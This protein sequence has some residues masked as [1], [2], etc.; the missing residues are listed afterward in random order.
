MGKYLDKITF[1]FTL[2]LTTGTCSPLMQKCPCKID[3]KTNTVDCSR[4]NPRLTAIPNCIPSSVQ[5]LNLSHNKFY[6]IHRRQFKEF[7]KLV[8]LDLRGC[9]VEYLSDEAFTGLP[10]L[11]TLLLTDNWIEVLNTTHFV[12]LSKLRVLDLSFNHIKNI[13]ELTFTGLA[14]LKQLSMA[15]NRLTHL[16]SHIFDGL[17]TLK[18]L[19][20][21]TNRLKYASSFPLDVF[22]PLTSLEEINI[23]KTCFASNCT[24]IDA[25]LTVL[26]SLKILHMDG[27]PNQ[28]LGPGFNSL[29]NLEEIYFAE[30]NL[31]ETTEMTFYN[32]KNSRLRTLWLT[33]CYINVIRPFSFSS[34][35]NLDSLII[36]NN[37][38][39]CDEGLLNIT[40][41]LNSTRIRHIDVSWT[42]RTSWSLSPPTIDKLQSTNLEILEFASSNIVFINP[43]VFIYLPQ[44]LKLLD[45]QGNHLQMIDLTYLYVL[46]SI[47]TLYINDQIDTESALSTGVEYP[48]LYNN[49][50]LP[51]DTKVT[52]RNASIQSSTELGLPS[53]TVLGVANASVA[54]N[55]TEQIANGDPRHPVE[56]DCFGDLPYK[57]HTIDLSNSGLLLGPIGGVV[58]IFCGSNNSLKHLDIS[59]QKPGKENEE[60]YFKVL[61][62]RLKNLRKLE[63]L[64]LSGNRLKDFPVH[65]FSKLTRL[66]R[67]SL[68]G[69]SLVEVKFDIQRLSSLEKLDL[70]NNRIAYLS[71]TFTLD[72]EK[73]AKHSN[74]TV[75]LYGNK[76]VCNCDHLKFVAWLRYTRVIFRKDNLTCEYK[77][78]SELAVSH[79]ADIHTVLEAECV[80]VAVLVSCIFVFVVLTLI[81]GCAAVVFDR[82][83]RF[84][85]LSLIGK[86]AINPYHP[87]EDREITLDYDIYISYAYDHMVTPT[88]SLHELVAQ[89][90]YPSLKQRGI[91]VII[92]EE[93]DAGRKLYDVI[94][95]TLRRSRK[96]VV[97]MTN[98][99]CQDHWN[100]FEFNMA[101]MEGIYTKREVIVPVILETLNLKDLHEEVY[102][103]LRSGPVARFTC[104]TSFRGLIEYLSESTRS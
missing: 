36:R 78:G 2:F 13:G 80:A 57:L 40:T 83:W 10:E 94:S 97:L 52:T 76:L 87:I 74:L 47:Q 91:Q 77:N 100:V 9:F 73:I 69:N 79:V 7:N 22:Q 51:I 19:D 59:N 104:E 54:D 82:R 101:V 42:C 15:A 34:L 102:A 46:G 81:L 60:N 14:N 99:Y 50:V 88:G 37:Y 24:Y 28:V 25:Q 75:Y 86:K 30:C 23:G 12:G 67:L 11:D 89:K 64:D 18:Q 33:L 95:Q 29:R 49:A 68:N 53:E 66:R 98:D 71:D 27:H 70:S 90:I 92:R 3:S 32:L 5:Q 20:L 84:K 96:V 1:I 93:L 41:G 55:Q 43:A 21:H 6:K 35:S 8:Y 4:R 63:T 38:K 26:K 39:L 58:Q 16:K 31:T 72:M 85:Y 48:R 17:S 62:M 56:V 61:L 65:V 45:L 103:Y 44:T